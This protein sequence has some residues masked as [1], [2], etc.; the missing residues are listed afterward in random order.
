MKGTSHEALNFAAV[1]SAPC[2][3]YVQNNQW[4][5]SVPLQSQTVAPSIAHKAIGYGMPGVRV[6]GNDVLACYAVMA[7]A[8]ARARRGDGPTLIEAITYRLAPHTTSDDPS[9]YRS[10]DKRTRLVADA[11]PNSALPEV[12]TD[13][14]DC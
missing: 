2:V 12:S 11:G 8:A 9:R 13:D 10:Q 3:F 5:I 6:D 4:A 7:E 14:L 1:F